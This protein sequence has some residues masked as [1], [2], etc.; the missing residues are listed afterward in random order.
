M[1]ANTINKALLEA[2]SIKLPKG[3]SMAHV[4]MD[5][6]LIGKEATYRRLRGEVPLS[7][8][9][10][11]ILVKKY[12]I[13]IDTLIETNLAENSVFELKTQRYYNLREKDYYMFYEYLNTLKYAAAE[14]YSDQ[15]FASNI[16]PMFPSNMYYMLAKYSSF[17]WLYLNQGSNTMM[18][19]DELEYPDE[20]SKVSKE[21][22]NA[23]MDIKNTCYIWDS[24]IFYYIVKEIKYFSKIHLIDKENIQKLKED[25]SSL[26]TFI[27]TIAISG[28]FENG[29]KIQIYI[30]NLNSDT[31]Y[32]YLDTER[33][34]ISMIGAFAP[35]YAVALD[36]KTLQKIKERI[37]SL[38]RISYLISESGEMQ[39][40]QFIKEQREIINTL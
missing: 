12:N 6:L 30:A 19:F 21:I 8:Y 1:D 5:T 40:I 17:R 32:S 4:L 39:R 38:K 26:L 24:T 23:T 20:L 11:A 10:A 36:K 16:F 37:L 31:S 9:E 3:T 33:M 14:S 7:M 15:V 22:V 27:E 18:T 25:L 29:N 34:H 2:I 28:K 35:N 13:S